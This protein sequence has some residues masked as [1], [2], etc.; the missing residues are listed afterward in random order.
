MQ[1][2]SKK[3]G[4]G[5]SNHDG[6]SAAIFFHALYASSYFGDILQTTLRPANVLR[7]FGVVHVCTIRAGRGQGEAGQYCISSPVLYFL[8]PTC[9][10]GII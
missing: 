1:L 5:D 9:A 3:Q 7:N 8:T 6:V 2:A 10:P 4:I